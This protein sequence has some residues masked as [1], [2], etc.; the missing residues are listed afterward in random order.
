[1]AAG[2][3][4]IWGLMLREGILKENIDGEALLWAAERLLLR[5]E[6]RRILMVISDGAP[7]DDFDALGQPRQLFG[8]TPARGHRL[9]GDSRHRS[10]CSPS[11]SATT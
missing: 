1:M 4:V 8:E 9:G 10:S 11:A 3:Q 7:V 6:Q 5:Q 2:A